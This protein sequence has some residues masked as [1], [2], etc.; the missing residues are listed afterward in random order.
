[1]IDRLPAL[2]RKA[3]L[4]EITVNMPSIENTEDEFGMKAFL[5]KSDTIRILLSQLEMNNAEM[6]ELASQHAAAIDSEQEKK[7]EIIK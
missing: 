2:H 6:N 1:M 4:K 3:V 5:A 7:I